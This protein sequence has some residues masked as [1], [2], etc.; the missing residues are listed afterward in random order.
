[1]IQ[2]RRPANE[3]RGG[4]PEEESLGEEPLTSRCVKFSLL[5]VPGHLCSFSLDNILEVFDF[6]HLWED[7]T[8]NG[9]V[10][11][12]RRSSLGFLNFEYRFDDRCDDCISHLYKIKTHGGS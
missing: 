5:E 4:F 1:M 12:P 6:S 11:Q 2:G 9:K 3:K 8:S 7:R 10:Y